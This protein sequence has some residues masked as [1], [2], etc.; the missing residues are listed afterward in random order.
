MNGELIW[1]GSRVNNVECS[2]TARFEPGSV[3]ST[4]GVVGAGVGV[5]VGVGF[6]VGV[7]AGVGFGVGVAVGLGVGVGAGVAP[8]TL[9]SKSAIIEL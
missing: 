6:G 9:R 7:G 3:S 4:G 2:A 8:S 5:G 1:N